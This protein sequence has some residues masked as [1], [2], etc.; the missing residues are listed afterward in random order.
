MTR[1]NITMPEGIADRL[2]KIAE[3]TKTSKSEIL[4]RALM[5]FEVAHN[6]VKEGKKVGI[7]SAEGRLEREFIGL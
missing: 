7:T 4:R 5:L 1:L 3:E 6:S 2:D